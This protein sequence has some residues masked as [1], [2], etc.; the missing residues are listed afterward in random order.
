MRQNLRRAP[1]LVALAI[2]LGL[3]VGWTAAWALEGTSCSDCPPSR[4]SSPTTTVRTGGPA[5]VESPVTSAPALMTPEGLP[6]TGG[7]IT[8]L[9]ALAA[10][11]GTLGIAM[12]RG[13]RPRGRRDGASTSGD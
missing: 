1:A 6:V 5:R 4:T 11:T 13:V 12:V 10:G 3:P 9:V 7:D 8:A 2:V